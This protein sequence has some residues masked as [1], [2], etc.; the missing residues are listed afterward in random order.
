MKIHRQPQEDWSDRRFQHQ[1]LT[2]RLALS[3]PANCTPTP[4]SN[5][6]Q[7]QAPSA[8]FP[9]SGAAGTPSSNG[10]PNVLTPA[11]VANTNSGLLDHVATVTYSN[12]SNPSSHLIT[13]IDTSD[14][15]ENQRGPSS[16]VAF[17]QSW[18]SFG[19]DPVTFYSIPEVKEAVGLA[20]GGGKEP[21]N[22]Q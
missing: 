4:G 11:S 15:G 13:N 20:T 21:V 17:H 7:P 8:V 10:N 18:G 9:T 3:L 22:W 16:I 5:L 19:P 12:V 2:H 14:S 1:L 6:L